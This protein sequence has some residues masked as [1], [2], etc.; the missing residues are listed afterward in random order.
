MKISVGLYGRILHKIFYVLAFKIKQQMSK[1]V[2][3]EKQFGPYKKIF[4]K[5]FG[6]E[7]KCDCGRSDSISMEYGYLFIEFYTILQ[8]LD[9]E[10]IM[11]NKIANEISVIL[12]ITPDFYIR[13]FSCFLGFSP[14][15]FFFK[16][17]YLFPF[18][19]N[20]KLT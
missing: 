11:I 1:H 2:H 10:T 19:Q 16:Y 3:T 13:L 18:A 7:M 4:Q 9:Q 17:I 5:H 15:Y 12:Y 20:E 8:N 14:V 6:G